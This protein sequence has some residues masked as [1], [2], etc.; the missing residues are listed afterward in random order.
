MAQPKN[1]IKEKGQDFARRQRQELR[2]MGATDAEVD[3][4]LRAA[5]PTWAVRSVRLAQQMMRLACDRDSDTAWIAARSTE[6]LLIGAREAAYK[7]EVVAEV[8]VNIHGAKI[9]FPDNPEAMRRL[10]NGALEVLGNTNL[11]AWD[12]SDESL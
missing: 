2:A 6:M 12:P 3:V 8:F 4:I 10:I 1:L 5:G 7:P 9:S 11:I